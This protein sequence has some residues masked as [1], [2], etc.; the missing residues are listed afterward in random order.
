MSR[1][2]CWIIVGLIVLLVGCQPSSD[3]LVLPTVA[4]MNMLATDDSATAMAIASPTRE[5][6]PPTFTPS[7]LPSATAT[8]PASVP[9]A[10]PAGFR[11]NGTIYYIFNGNSIV[12]LAADGTFEDL[13]P[14]PQI[15]QEITGLALSP[16]ETRLAYV[17]PGSGSAREI[18][19][20]DRRGTNTRQLSQ[21]GFSVMQTPIWKPDSSALAFIAA[22]GPESPRGIYVVNADG[23]GHRLILQLPSLEM[24]DLAWS[25]DGNWLFYSNQTIYAVNVGTGAP[26]GT[27]TKL[28]GYGPDIVPV[29]NPVKTELYYLK[30][31]Y[32]R[33][34]GQ[35][36][37]VLASFDTST[38]PTVPFEREGARLFVDQLEFSSNGN[39]LLISGSEGIWVQDQTSLTSPKIAQGLPVPPRPTFNSDGEQI[40]YINL[41]GLGIAQIFLIGRQ[42]G[43]TT[44]IT[45]HQEGTI[46]DLKWAAG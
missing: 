4:D 25:L 19:I 26:T 1:R 23:S 39:H 34:T 37:G 17:A 9:T 45:F 28:S 13:L 42:G 35:S 38:M 12:E 5:P 6:L 15:G 31:G 30:G 2:N 7:P 11:A 16:D 18:Y 10:A 41:D 20:T 22:Q 33:N 24:R 21:L 27:L 32:D 8:D 3:T 14:I 46:S 43:E 44:Q 36:G 40:A 29:H